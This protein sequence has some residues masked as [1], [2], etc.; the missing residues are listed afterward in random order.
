MRGVRV[1]GADAYGI[2]ATR[3]K[4]RLERVLITR[5]TTREGDSGDGLHLRD[6]EVEAEDVVV[7]DVAGV[8]VLGAQGSRVV[9]REVSLEGCKE[10]GV[11]VET[12]G[13][14]TA[15]GLQVRGSGGPALLALEDGVLRV[16]SLTVRDNA[17]G[18]VLA[19]CQGGTK[20]TLRRVMEE[21]PAQGTAGPEASCVGRAAP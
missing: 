13:Q 6:A 10:A 18:L 5:L 12:L 20:V 4:I 21:G 15:V 8:G 14:V 19:D 7:R 17:G 3:G 1:D 11:Q 16:D 9:L 2:A